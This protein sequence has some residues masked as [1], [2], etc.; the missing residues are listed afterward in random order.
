MRLRRGLVGA[1]RRRKIRLQTAC[2]QRAIEPAAALAGGDGQPAGPRQIFHQLFYA[3]EQP[4][5]LFARQEMPAVEP[6]ELGIALRGQ[7]GDRETQRIVQ[8]EADDVAR[9]LPVRHLESQVGARLLDAFDDGAGGIDQ[10]AIPVED[11]ERVAHAR[12]LSMNS[13]MSLGSFDSKR[14]PSPVSG[15]ANP[16]RRACR[17]RRRTPSFAIAWFSGKSP[18]LSSPRIGC[19]ACARWTR[20][21]CVRPVSRRTSRTL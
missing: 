21:W 19:P 9:A 2:L 20:I 6:D 8:P 10:C 13:C 11:D 4:H 5:R 7:T 12:R 16:S 18:Y 3:R 14:I 17:K 1:A 15:C